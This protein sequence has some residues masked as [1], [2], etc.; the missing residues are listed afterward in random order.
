ML[1]LRKHATVIIY[2]SRTEN[3]AEACKDSDILIAAVGRPKMIKGDFVVPG[4]IVI[5]VGINA[6]P[7]NPGKYR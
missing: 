4:M 1:L 3:L 6:D 2:H 7:D 5:D